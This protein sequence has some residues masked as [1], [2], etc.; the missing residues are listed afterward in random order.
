LLTER[1]RAAP[2]STGVAGPDTA[3]ASRSAA[4]DDA[5][6]YRVVAELEGDNRVPHLQDVARRRGATWS[7]P[8][9]LSTG[10]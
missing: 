3:A 8:A 4:G 6:V 2:L 1:T 9:P 10:F 7:R 5:V